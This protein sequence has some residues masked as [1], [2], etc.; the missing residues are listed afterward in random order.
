MDEI[1]ITPDLEFD[2]KDLMERVD[3]T[4]LFTLMDVFHVCMNS[5]IPP[6]ILT[7]ILQCD[8]QAFCEEAE[9]RPFEEEGDIEYLELS[10]SGEIN[11]E[12]SDATGWQFDG[13]GREGFVPK[14]IMESCPNE[15]I[16]P[17]WRQHYAIELSPLYKLSGYQ[18][19]IARKISIEDWKGMEER[20]KGRKKTKE[21]YDGLTK[22]IGIQPSIT[23]IELLYNVFWE[24]SFFGSPDGRDEKKDEINQTMEE[25]DKAKADGTLKLL[26]TEEVEKSVLE[27][28]KKDL[29]KES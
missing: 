1:K 10:Y 14:D 28:L 19:K 22:E 12:G 15:I 6:E 17:G 20:A 9:S 4:H 21:D 3:T 24:L 2:Y 27:H 5:K 23:L 13:V 8:Y 7:E 18:I 25:Y 29:K 16:P 11:S 26:S